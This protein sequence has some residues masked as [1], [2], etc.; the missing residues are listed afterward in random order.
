MTRD[1]I[2][3]EIKR[4]YAMRRRDIWIMIQENGWNVAFMVKVLEMKTNA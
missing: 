1:K 3:V 4:D 2:Y